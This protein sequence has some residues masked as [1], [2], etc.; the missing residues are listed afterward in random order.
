[1]WHMVIYIFSPILI[2]EIILLGFIILGSGKQVNKIWPPEEEKSL[3][4][5]I[6][7]LVF[8]LIIAGILWIAII[9]RTNPFF[10]VNWFRYVGI[11]LLL[12]GICLYIWCRIYISKKVEFGGKDQLVTQGPYKYSRNPLYIADTLIF[13]GFA[14]FSNSMLVFILMI[15]LV[16]TL[17]LLPL[18]E[19]PWLLKQYGKQYEDY[20]SGVPRYF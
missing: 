2:L 16:A 10:T 6:L 9:E 7:M 17:L 12:L 14:I 8:Y 4:I 11:S 3:S 15:L 20:K 13:L 1:M 19:E 18:V 5:Y